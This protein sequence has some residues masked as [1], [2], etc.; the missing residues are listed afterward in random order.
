[1]IRSTR[2]PALEVTS[3]GQELNGLGAHIGYSTT[4]AVAQILVPSL[5]VQFQGQTMHRREYHHPAKQIF[6][7]RSPLVDA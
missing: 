2:D 7:K 4:T 5:S 6:A 3:Q 1:M